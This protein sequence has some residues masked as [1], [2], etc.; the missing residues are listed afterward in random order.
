MSD[1]VVQPAD[2]ARTVADEAKR[3]DKIITQDGIAAIFAARYADR[4]RY[5]HS[6]R[7]W[8]HFDGARW[9]RD[10]TNR[11][12]EF[13]RLIARELSE[14]KEHRELK[15]FRKTAFAS[16]VE[17]FAQND[18]I[19]A[20]TAENWDRDP[21]LLGTPAGTVDLRT[22]VLRTADPRDA[23]TKSTAVSPSEH[24]D[25]PIWL[26]FLRQATA[27]DPAMV[28]FLQQWAGYSLT[29]D[30]REHA[31]LFLHGPGG[32]GKSVFLNT[33][34]GIMR[35]YAI[36]APTETFTVAIGDRHPT[37]VAALCGA[38]LVAAS[39]TEHSRTW[40]ETRI[41]QLT[42][43]D[44]VSARFM[45]GDFFRFRPTFKLI[46]V[47]NHA[48]RLG[49]VDAAIR[50][51]FNVVPFT[52]RPEKPD[53]S[54]E[55]KLRDEWPQ[56]LRWMITGCLDWLRNGLQRPQRVLAATEDYFSDQ[57]LLGQWLASCCD[58]D[59]RNDR[60]RETSGD[61]YE[62]WKVFAMQAGERPESQKAFVTNLEKS[63]ERYR[64]KHGRGFKGIRLKRST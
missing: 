51:R 40:A 46:V 63:V 11:A 13:V 58:L 38:R 47:G 18:P 39:E 37:E 29:G 9:R 49:T 15:E 32:N 12:F 10:E 55:E 61:L 3:N 34:N 1:I 33:I 28:R 2:V 64:D 20:V 31:L 41:K 62:A 4:L 23:I 14:G 44:E 30:T 57:D 19:L 6:S 35:D 48:P 27:D 43:G 60:M 54:L 53:L 52:H 26:A 24:I 7:A 45:R 17:K 16:G 59:P 5:C 36:P 8:Y 25:C 21:F 50:R 42:G 22:G 56:I